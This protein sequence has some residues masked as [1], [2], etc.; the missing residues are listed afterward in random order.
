MSCPDCFKGAV[1][2]HSKPQGT[3]VALYGKRT[4]VALPPASSTSASTI[5]YCC[6][7]FGLNLVNNKLL[8]DEYAAATGFRVLVPDQIP[9]GPI[10]LA[11]LDVMDTLT[12]KVDF[13]DIWG[14]LRRIK[15]VL[16]AARYFVPFMIRANPSK[17]VPDVLAYARKVKAEL[18]PGAKLGICGFCWGGYMST[19]LSAEP[20]VA[21]GTEKLIDAQFCAHPSALKAPG[22]I[23]DAV[24]KFQVPYSLAHASLDF[25]LTTKG[26]EETEAILR[27]KV[28]NGEGENGCHY[29]LKTYKDCHHGFAARAKPGDEVEFQGAQDAKVQ[30]IEWFKKFL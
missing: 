7:A 6:D 25:N 27:Q 2:D 17:A 3:E 1:H 23:V 16:M 28:D 5:I 15:A 12:N 29:E 14:Q 11:V 21:G 30:A 22:M 13:W 24:T 10:S 20:A 26:V 18:P 4:Y 9:G 8:A 19:A